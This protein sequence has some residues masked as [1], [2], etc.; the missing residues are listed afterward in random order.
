MN[1]LYTNVVIFCFVAAIGI[2]LHHIYIHPEYSFPD[3]AFQCSDIL[4]HETW[5]IA[6]LAF[7]AGIM[8]AK[9]L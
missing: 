3:R 7:A 5:V 1:T 9:S 2:V 4:N 6:L 8:V